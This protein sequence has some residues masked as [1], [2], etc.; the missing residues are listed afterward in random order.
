MKKK[1]YYSFSRNFVTK[2]YV[3][4]FLIVCLGTLIYSFKSS[5]S[6]GLLQAEAGCESNDI[7][8][9]KL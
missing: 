7:N 4:K 6:E 8:W 9:S 2:L 3:C 5:L 1:H